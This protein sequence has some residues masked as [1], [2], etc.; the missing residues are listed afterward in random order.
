M[1]N[2]ETIESSTLNAV[3]GGNVP[4]QTPSEIC[5]PGTVKTASQNNFGFDLPGRIPNIN[6][7]PIHTNNGRLT[8]GSQ[9]VECNPPSQ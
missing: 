2:F 4:M 1:S 6:A 9:S 5:A 7:G 3:V 8:I